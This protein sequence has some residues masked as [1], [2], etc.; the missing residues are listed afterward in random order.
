MA[1]HMVLDLS[2]AT[3]ADLE[4]FLGAARA[5][6][7][8]RDTALSFEAEQST[9]T[10]SVSEEDVEPQPGPRGPR[11]GHGRHDDGPHP[12]S[13]SEHRPAPEQRGPGGTFPVD[14]PIGGVGEAAVRS[15]IDI[16]TGK[17]KPPRD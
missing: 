16:L 13:H 9:L 6:G 7:A 5:V 4:R 12:G 17:Q 1:V 3:L 11:P 15:V 2:D 10:V 14:L 8:K